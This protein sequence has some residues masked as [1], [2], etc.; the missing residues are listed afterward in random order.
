MLL[1]YISII[2]STTKIV[3]TWRT[4]LVG[5]CCRVLGFIMLKLV[6]NFFTTS[7]PPV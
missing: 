4:F 1:L 6:T 5:I 7:L 3:T 2:Q